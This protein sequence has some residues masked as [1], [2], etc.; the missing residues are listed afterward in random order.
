MVLSRCQY[1]ENWKTKKKPALCMECYWGNPTNYNHIA[2]KSIRRLDVQWA[3]DEVKYYDA[4]KIIAD[5]NKIELP[6]FVKRI[7]EDKAK[8]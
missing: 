7:I 5:Q 8:K 4:I 2:L 1:C 6:S 3:G